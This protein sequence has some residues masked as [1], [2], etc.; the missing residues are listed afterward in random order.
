MYSMSTA[1]ED[2]RPPQ[3]RVPLAHPRDARVIFFVQETEDVIQDGILVESRRAGAA[4]APLGAG[5]D[6]HFLHRPRATM[7]RLQGA[8]PGVIAFRVRESI[9]NAPA[10]SAQQEYGLLVI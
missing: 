9:S 8:A 2:E 1:R 4:A 7:N 10:G 5:R 6:G 3:R